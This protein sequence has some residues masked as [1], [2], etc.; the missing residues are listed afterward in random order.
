MAYSDKVIDHYEN[1]R[2]VGSFDKADDAVGTGMVGA[3]AG[4][5]PLLDP[6][7]GCDQGRGRGL[8]EKAWAG[9]YGSKGAEGRVITLTETAAKHV[10]SY[11]TKRGKGVGLRVGVQIG[12]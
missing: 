9:R 2:N 12:R 7:R 8:Q 11:M 6:R 3:P 1:P 5:D 4:Q 10:Q